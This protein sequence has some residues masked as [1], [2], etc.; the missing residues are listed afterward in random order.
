LQIILN[1]FVNAKTLHTFVIP[2]TPGTI[3]EIQLREALLIY[4]GRF[5]EGH[6][7]RDIALTTLREL[8]KENPFNRDDIKGSIRHIDLAFKNSGKQFNSIHDACLSLGLPLLQ[9]KNDLQTVLK[10]YKLRV[11]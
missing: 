9:V 10:K 7:L 11:L 3:M 5:P 8:G 6:P 2:T 4:A 1:Y